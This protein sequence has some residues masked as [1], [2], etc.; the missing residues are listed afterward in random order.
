MAIRSPRLNL[1]IDLSY[2]EL[3]RHGGDMTRLPTPLRVVATI[4]AAQGVINNGG[5]QYFFEA[6]FPGCPPYKTFIEA[7]RAIGAASAAD[8][9][10]R[11]VALFQFAEPNKDVKA[12]NEFLDSFKDEDD[13]PANSPFEPLTKALCGNEEVWICLEAFVE[14]HSEALQ[15]P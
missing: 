7:Y 12:R 8:A 14:A 3:E 2:S 13:E 5:L 10:A 15:A 9:L 6:D 1:A 4:V 11:A